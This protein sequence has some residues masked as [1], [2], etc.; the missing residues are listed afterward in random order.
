[1]AREVATFVRAVRDW[2]NRLRAKPH[3]PNQNPVSDWRRAVLWLWWK[4]R[5]PKRRQTV[6]LEH[7]VGGQREKCFKCEKEQLPPFVVKQCFA[8]RCRPLESIQPMRSPSRFRHLSPYPHESVVMPR[9]AAVWPAEGQ[10][11]RTKSCC[12]LMIQQFT[13]SEQCA[14]AW[15]GNNKCQDHEF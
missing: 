1:M 6:H 5:E 9:C 13:V 11:D 2:V 4:A 10:R 14:S 15:R 7:W 8:E 3:H 12:C